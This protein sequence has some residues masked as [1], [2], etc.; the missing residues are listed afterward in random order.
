M[1]RDLEE[2]EEELERVKVILLWP[3]AIS[4][5]ILILLNTFSCIFG[6]VQCDFEG[7][8]SKLRNEKNALQTELAEW[9]R[10]II[11]QQKKLIRR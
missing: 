1:A 2:A 11:G 7:Q 3:A 4:S 6:L 9:K 10:K 8:V 5:I